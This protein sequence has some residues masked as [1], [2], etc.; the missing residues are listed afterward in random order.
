MTSPRSVYLAGPDV[1][2]ADSTAWA[3]GER[4]LGEELVQ[5]RAT[6]DVDMGQLAPFL[7]E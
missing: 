5:S 4:K 6:A 3:M 1:F 2:R 7:I